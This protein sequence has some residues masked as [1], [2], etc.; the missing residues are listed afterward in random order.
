MVNRVVFSWE[1]EREVSLIIWVT[2]LLNEEDWVLKES[3]VV[4]TEERLLLT[5]CIAE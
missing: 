3:T 2:L 4:V 5:V 1:M